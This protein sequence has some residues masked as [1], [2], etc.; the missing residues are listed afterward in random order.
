M[1]SVDG[2]IRPPDVWRH[3]RSG[4]LSCY[5]EG[6][7]Q[8]FTWPADAVTKMAR[9]LRESTAGQA[10][11]P[12]R[13]FLDCHERLEHLIREAGRGP[14]DAVIVDIPRAELTVVWEDE[15]VV[16]TIEGIGG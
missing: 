16:V 2:D 15:Q 7:E 9:R 6:G 5:Y 10:P 4:A 1:Q 12:L 13:P 11:E 3:E 14:A 8:V